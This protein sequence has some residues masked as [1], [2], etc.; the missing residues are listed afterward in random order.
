MLGEEIVA[1]LSP[2]V[3]QYDRIT[4][5][6]VCSNEVCPVV[7]VPTFSPSSVLALYNNKELT[8]M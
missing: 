3:L 1:A 8:Q 7:D 6:Y 5:R 4:I 2:C